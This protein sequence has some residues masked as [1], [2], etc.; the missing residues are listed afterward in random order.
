MDK[1]KIFSE[2]LRGLR[3]SLGKKQG[4]IL[5][6]KASTWGNYESGAS[7]PILKDF[8][9]ICEFFGVTEFEILN[10]THLTDDP[11][12]KK[13]SGKNTP[14][15]TPNYTPNHEVYL[16]FNEDQGLY[17]KKNEADVVLTHMRDSMKTKDA[18]IAALQA[19][20]EMYKVQLDECKKALKA[21]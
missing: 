1:L 9:K 5:D 21:G 8:I 6:I 19:Q 10:D 20:I 3:K 12:T 13:K 7:T 18:L 4:E 17:L 16:Q 11:I 14:N 2:N 15:S